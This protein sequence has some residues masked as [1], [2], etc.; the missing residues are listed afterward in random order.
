MQYVYFHSAVTSLSMGMI[1]YA[2]S[3]LE[4]IVNNRIGKVGIRPLE[5]PW[6]IL[7][8]SSPYQQ[9]RVS[10]LPP[11]SAYWISVHLYECLSTCLSVDS[12]TRVSYHGIRY[13]RSHK[14]R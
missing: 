10:H 4:L 13:T 14:R 8:L 7:S 5:P 1:L 11:E 2:K 6:P 9:T 3:S 12:S